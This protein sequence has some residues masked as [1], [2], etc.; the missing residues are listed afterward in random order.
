[1]ARDK[2]TVMVLEFQCRGSDHGPM[3][4]EL[5]GLDFPAVPPPV[6]FH[7]NWGE[8][9]WDGNTS[10][11]KSYAYWFIINGKKELMECFAA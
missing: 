1:M 8:G 11:N 3:C 7:T 5:V 6:M 9:V 2:D 4:C 10:D